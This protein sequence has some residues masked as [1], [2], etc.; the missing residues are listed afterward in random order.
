MKDRLDRPERPVIVAASAP[1]EIRHVPAHLA[2][3][4]RTRRTPRV[5]VLHATHGAEGTMADTNGAREMT[6]P[7]V[8]PRS[9]HYFVDADSCT[10]CVPDECRAY[11]A[12]HNGNAV[13]IGVELCGR[14]DQ[15]IEQWYDATSL[16]TMRLAARLCIELCLRWKLPAVLV[17]PTGLRAGEPGITTHALVSQAWH[18]SDHWDPGPGFPLQPFIDA[19]ARGMVVLGPAPTV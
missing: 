16:A 9:A 7:I 1:L 6:K 5:I 14:A 18:E 4:S 10:Q 15:T 17:G 12:R 3:Y 11:H 8:P 2:N 13:G 19:V